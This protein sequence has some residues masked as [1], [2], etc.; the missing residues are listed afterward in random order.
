MTAD[1]RFSAPGLPGPVRFTDAKAVLG[2]VQAVLVGWQLSEQTVDRTAPRPALAVT[3]SGGRWRITGVTLEAEMWFDDPV[4]AACCVVAHLLQAQMRAEQDLLCL[5]AA[6]VEIGGGLVVMPCRY[7]AGKSALTAALAA[8]G[9]RAFSDDV[10]LIDPA[11]GEAAAPGMAIRLRLPLPE[12]IDSD[13]R[14]FVESHTGPCGAHYCYLAPPAASLARRGERAP[15]RSFVLLDRRDAGPAELTRVAPAVML[16]QLIWQNFARAGA[17]ERILET[18][19]ALVERADCLQ[20]TYSDLAAARELL[21]SHFAGQTEALRDAQAA[22]PCP[23]AAVPG[24]GNPLALRTGDRLAR[25]ATARL[26]NRAGE[27]FLTTAAS[28]GILHLN[29]LASC[30]WTLLEQPL[31]YG[32]VLATFSAA[33]PSRATADLDRDLRGALAAF[34]AQGLIEVREQPATPPRRRCAGLAAAALCGA[35]ACVEPAAAMTIGGCEGRDISALLAPAASAEWQGEA[36]ELAPLRFAHGLTLTCDGETCRVDGGLRD[37]GPPARP[38]AATTLGRT[39]AGIAGLPLGSA[40]P[41]QSREIVGERA[42]HLTEALERHGWRD[43]AGDLRFVW[44]DYGQL[45]GRVNLRARSEIRCAVGANA[46]T[47]STTV[48][49][50]VG[51]SERRP[52]PQF[53]AP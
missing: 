49:A 6:A 8:A 52:C 24:I 46:C 4:S 41:T 20:L 11:S 1:R 34:K 53:G 43:D 12:R 26:F 36:R 29:A 32:E 13:T 33:F 30:L 50:Y 5:H 18:L 21:L 9:Q 19:A 27:V 31:T 47:L 44:V 22:T 3:G 45:A 17:P 2:A 15:V 7:R 14:A 10:L 38:A 25:S 39:G 37:L 48:L 28:A 23:D 42:A 16:R 35:L 40:P 51:Y